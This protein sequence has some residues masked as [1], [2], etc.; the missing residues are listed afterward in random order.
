MWI[1]VRA[2]CDLLTS[3][4]IDNFDIMQAGG[5][6]RPLEADPPLFVSE[7][8][9]LAASAALDNLRPFTGV[10]RMSQADQRGRGAACRLKFSS[11]NAF[12]RQY[13]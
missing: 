1:G 7:D 11:G 2:I 3:V 8:A 4:V 9:E 6:A 12:R 13:V 5:T 10:K